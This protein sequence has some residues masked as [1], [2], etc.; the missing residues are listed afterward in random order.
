M[1]EASSTTTTK[2]VSSSHIPYELALCILAKL[3][4]KSLKR[5]TC[6]QKSWSLLFQSSHFINMFSINCMSK[7]D[8]DYENTCLLLFGH[9]GPPE[10]RCAM[11]SLSSDNFEDRVRID[12]PPP[13]QGNDYRCI[14]PLGSC[15]VNGIIC[16]YEGDENDNN[17]TTVLW[18]PA[19]GEFKIIPPSIHYNIEFNFCPDAF[20]YDS[21]TDDYKVLRNALIDENDLFMEDPQVEEMCD[22]FWEIY[23]LKSNS[24]RKLDGI[25]LPPPGPCI[26][27]VNLNELCHWLVSELKNHMLSFDFSTEKFLAT[28]LPLDSDEKKECILQKLIV[29]NGSVAFMCSNYYDR[30]CFHI[31][32]LGEL[33]VKES[34]TKLF[35]VGPLPC[36]K[37]IPIGAG[38]KNDIYFAQEYNKLSQFNLSTQKCEELRIN[39]GY[40]VMYKKV[41]VS[42]PHLVE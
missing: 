23:S 34:W 18:N 7:Q 17:T 4:L 36:F 30:N 41:L 16:I 38:K 13:F 28:T 40:T 2:K 35:I 42:I 1:A 22:T 29:L 12:W 6:V 33:G 32:I 5:F 3:P 19:T 25:N 10:N 15:S 39:I 9:T 20:G 37:S 14:E 24:W 31:W 26:S 11:Y 21:I 27:L 8:E